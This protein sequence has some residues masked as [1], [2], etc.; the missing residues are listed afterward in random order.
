MLGLINPK[1]LDDNECFRWCHNRKLNPE[2]VHPERIKNSDKESVKRI[3][4]FW[5]YF[6]SLL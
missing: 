5:N 4:L 3:R 2:K 1:N 6:S